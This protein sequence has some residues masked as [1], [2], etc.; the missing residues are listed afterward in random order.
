M[1]R[2]SFAHAARHGRRRPAAEPSHPPLLLGRARRRGFVPWL[3]NCGG[4]SEPPAFPALPPA[5]H[6][7]LAAPKQPH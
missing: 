4:H 6:N 7:F 5:A 3:S 1:G 2:F